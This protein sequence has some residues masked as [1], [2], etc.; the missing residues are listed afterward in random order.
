VHRTAPW[1]KLSVQRTGFP[2]I[3]RCFKVVNVSPGPNVRVHDNNLAN[4]QR[5]ITERIFCVEGSGGLE[6]PPKPREGRFEL[7][8][9][10]FRSRLGNHLPR[11][12][13]AGYDQFV[14]QCPPRKRKLYAEAVESLKLQRVCRRDAVTTP[15]LKAE[16]VTKADPAPRIISARNPRYNV[17]VGRFLKPLEHKIYKS[18]AKVY[19]DSTTRIDGAYRGDE[20]NASVFRGSPTVM[21]GYN[22]GQTGRIMADKWGRLVDPVGV[23]LDASRFDQHTCK[24]A[25][26]WE[27]GVYAS[28]FSGPER[29]E[30]ERLLSWQLSNKAVAKAGDGVIRYTVEGC[31]MSG[32]MNTALGNCLIMC[33]MVYSYLVDRCITKYEVMNNGDDVVV[34]L[35]RR[36][37]DKFMLGLTDWFLE[38]GYKMAVEKPVF[39]LEE[40][41]FCHTKPVWTPEGYVMV[42][43]FPENLAKDSYTMVD[44]SVPKTARKWLA[45][46]GAGGMSITGGMPVLQEFYLMYRRSGAGVF[47]ADVLEGSGFWY[48]T[49]GMRRSYG[50]VH[51]LTRAS[52]YWAFGILPDLQEALERMYQSTSIDCTLHT[53]PLDESDG[54]LVIAPWR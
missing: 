16:G 24:D 27:H 34:M 6:R 37:L 20:N 21:K 26:R 2:K 28:C 51:P 44:L 46:V 25:L 4:L 32:D 41:E 43:N 29:T 38:C 49:R 11:A 30:L 33:G 9:A 23:G 48:M 14:E 15:F 53:L 5:G 42:R 13:R 47:R 8:L 39:V 50:P 1:V 17:E 18:I 45:A 54:T 3:R 22:A 12:T 19:A 10:K 31:R 36:D 40:L 52:F 35:E 7:L